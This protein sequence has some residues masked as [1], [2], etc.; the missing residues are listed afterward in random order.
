ML[1]IG[2]VFFCVAKVA[3][4]SSCAT[5]VLLFR[6]VLS[7][8]SLTLLS[9]FALVSNPCSCAVS[10]GLDETA[11]LLGPGLLAADEASCCALERMKER[12]NN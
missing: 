8:I 5:C 10:C 11:C 3:H 6:I 7:S 9:R 12:I 1:S 2:G 4:T